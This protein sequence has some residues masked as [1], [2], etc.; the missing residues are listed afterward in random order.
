VSAPSLA[1]STA[2]TGA[3]IRRLLVIMLVFIL[4]GPPI[5]TMVLMLASVLQGL[6][7]NAGLQGL[8]W[9]DLSVIIYVVPFAYM[10]GVLPAAAAGFLVG[11]W[12]AFKGPASWWGAAAIGVLVA[13][14]FLAATGQ[15]IINPKEYGV[16]R[17][18]TWLAIVV[19]VGPTLACWAIVQNWH[20]AAS[21]PEPLHG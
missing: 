7:T 8:T 11:L 17:D 4:L 9:T 5:G 10:V 3:R 16:A 15:P 13:L 21:M 1:I 18:Q 12:Q 14:G 19:C 2:T 6:V 20:F